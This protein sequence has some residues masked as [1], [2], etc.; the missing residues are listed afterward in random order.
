MCAIYAIVQFE[1][2]SY[3]D[4]RWTLQSR[5]P[6]DERQRA[7]SD[8]VYIEQSTRR[9]CKVVKETY[10]PH[11]NRHDT[12][13]VYVSP[14]AKEVMARLKT[15]A[16][17]YAG[18][19]G[20][21][22]A[23]RGLEARAS[24]AARLPV[25]ALAPRAADLFWRSIIAMGL[26][27]L[28]ATVVTAMV[29]WIMSRL[30]DFGITL[31]PSASSLMLTAVYMIVFL[32]GVLSMFRFGAPIKRLISILWA[33]AAPAPASSA[34]DRAAA[35]SA[36]GLRL[37][38]KRRGTVDFERQ[39]QEAADVKVA[40]GDLDAIAPAPEPPAPVPPPPIVAEPPAPPQAP[41]AAPVPPA[42][43]APPPLAETTAAMPAAPAQSVPTP[44][45]EIPAVQG[46]SELHRALAMRFALE[47][48]L[49]QIA[50]A[51]DDPIARRG[52]ALFMT[53]AM[54][55]LAALSNLG[56]EGEM[57]LTVAA[58]PT[59]LPRHAVDAYIGQYNMHVTSP[60]NVGLLTQGRQAMARF[61]GGQNNDGALAA[62]LAAWRSPQP[63]AGPASSVQGEPAPTDYYLV[64]ELRTDHMGAMAVHNDILRE[65][66]ERFDGT[67]LKHTGRGILARFARADDAIQAAL[68]FAGKLAAAGS[69]PPDVMFSVALVAGRGAGDDPLLSTSVVTAAQAMLDAA[70]RGGII[71][72]PVVA[73]QASSTAPLHI[74]P[75][76]VSWVKIA[77]A[78]QSGSAAAEDAA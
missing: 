69:V 28:A 37:R 71:G 66:L 58:L 26:S 14:K 75:F 24:S 51:S 62:A 4:G 52:A 68:A 59:A 40:R 8:A 57:S 77:P 17:G 55:H 42:P 38:P 46:V 33:H 61:L 29:S 36:A 3:Q 72:Q 9:P 21:A 65:T 19:A 12:V 25:R 53:G 31:D 2:H 47:V 27:L 41:P 44:V 78:P 56:A 32:F 64:S 6:S 45:P 35:F 34:R 16:A 74:E 10:Y 49:P 43:A 13:T 15:P 54:A 50:R 7:I 70:P 11:E 18:E 48:M 76:A 1:V 20:A 5:F 22:R 60:A 23:A 30:P 39:Q 63:L 73:Q 67:E